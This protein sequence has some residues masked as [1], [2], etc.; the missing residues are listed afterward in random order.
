MAL[1]RGTEVESD[2]LCVGDCNKSGGGDDC[3]IALCACY[4]GYV[5]AEE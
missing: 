5:P 1:A 3:G 4:A 2:G